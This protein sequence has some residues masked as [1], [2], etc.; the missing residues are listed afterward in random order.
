M[1]AGQ[2]IRGAKMNCLGLLAKTT[3]HVVTIWAGLSKMRR[4]RHEQKDL[5][6]SAVITFKAYSHEWNQE[7]V[8]RYYTVCDGS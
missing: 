7:K 1:S 4:D 8:T 3:I 5:L 2:K 6:I